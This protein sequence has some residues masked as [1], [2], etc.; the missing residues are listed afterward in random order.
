MISI[1]EPHE[2]YTQRVL[3]VLKSYKPTPCYDLVKIT[4]RFAVP[5]NVLRKKGY[6]IE[7]QKQDK[8]INRKMH[9]NY[10]LISE[11]VSESVSKISN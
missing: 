7:T 9:V 8:Y 1:F 11:P 6:V 2:N 3:E 10:L 4:H 5:I